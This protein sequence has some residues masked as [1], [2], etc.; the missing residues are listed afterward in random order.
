MLE[1][2][3]FF[4]KEQKDFISFPPIDLQKTSK[5]EIKNFFKNTYQ[6]YEWLFSSVSDEGFYIAPDPLRR[7]LI[8]YLGH[9]SAVYINKMKLLKLVT[10]INE[11]FEKIFAVGVNPVFAEEL[12]NDKYHEI[13]PKLKEVWDYRVVVYNKVIE[14]M[15]KSKFSLPVKRDSIWWLLLLGMEHDRIHFETTTC[16]L[17]QMDLKYL[18]NPINWKSAGYSTTNFP[19]NEFIAVEG[20]TVHLGKA[21]DFPSFG[22]DNEYGSVDMDVYPFKATKYKITNGE[23]LEFMKAGDYH[24]KSNWTKEGWSWKT[25]INN[26]YPRFWVKEKKKFRFRNTFDVID[27]PLNWPVEIIFHEAEAYCNWLAKKNKLTDTYYRLPTE[28]EFKIIRGDEEIII[29]DKLVGCARDFGAFS[30]KSEKIGNVNCFYGTSNPVDEFKPS[31]RGFYDTVGNVWEWSESYFRAYPGFKPETY[32]Y[33]YSG[34]CYEYGH[35]LLLGAAWS[36]TGLTCSNYVRF[37]FR[38]HFP[39]NAGFRIVEANK[40]KVVQDNTYEQKKIIS[41]YI[42]TFYYNNILK[43]DIFNDLKIDIPMEYNVDFGVKIADICI[44]QYKKFNNIQEKQ[45]KFRAFDLGC[46]VGKTAFALTRFFDEVEGLEYSKNFVDI[47]N[48]I[49]NYGKMDFEYLRNGDNLEK[50]TLVLDQSFDRSKTN[51]IHGDAMHLPYELGPY[52]LI[53]VVNLIDRLTNP[54][55]GLMDLHN[56]LNNKGLLVIVSPYTFMECY[57]PKKN[58]IGGKDGESSFEALEKLMTGLCFN[59]V[60]HTTTSLVM[61]EHERKYQLCLPHVTVW[62]KQPYNEEFATSIFKKNIPLFQ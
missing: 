8:F 14:M 48:T 41:E 33:D 3:A 16:L 9:T 61:R 17:R 27:M 35:Y 22:W 37:G 31:P 42:I 19:N 34:P 43:N 40:I 29:R 56:K 1:A 4:P 7:E 36:S 59:L 11:F 21:E 54:V 60:D 24:D 6:M 55:Q 38:R 53:C 20:Q 46:G 10:P 30:K 50:A 32:Y 26:Q 2:K 18:K 58:W 45:K 5:Q 12:D 15:D 49:K 57:T 44:D 23:F 47:C 13:W 51:F 52:D 28:E 62:K 25:E 39:Q